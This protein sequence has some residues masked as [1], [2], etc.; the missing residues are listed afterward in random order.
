MSEPKQPSKRVYTALKSNGRFSDLTVTEIRSRLH[1]LGPDER[2]HYL[3][4]GWAVFETN[5]R[6]TE[7]ERC[8]ECCAILGINDHDVAKLPEAQGALVVYLREHA[9]PAFTA[10]T[11]ARIAKAVQS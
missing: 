9:P 11:I 1:S 5:T 4:P 8:D 6:G 7:I 3:C 10:D 2:C